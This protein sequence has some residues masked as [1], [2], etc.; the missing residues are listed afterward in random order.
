M[1]DRS[2]SMAMSSPL[3]IAALL[4]SCTA[5][6]RREGELRVELCRRR[7]RQPMACDH[8]D[9]AHG[10]GRQV[11]AKLLRLDRDVGAR[12]EGALAH[13]RCGP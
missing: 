2:T 13:R 3:N 7:R 6:M 4:G 1:V 10:I 12:G 8:P 5:L 11:D 9:P